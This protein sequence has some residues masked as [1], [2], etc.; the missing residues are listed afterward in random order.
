M[1]QGKS[2]TALGQVRGLGS[3]GHGGTHWLRERAT[4]AALVLLGLWLIASLLLLPDLR[5]GTVLEWLSAPSGA[6]PMFLFVA[7]AFVHSLDG[8][9][10]MIDDYVHDESNRLLAHGIVLFA[11]VGAGALAL[12]SLARIA[13]GA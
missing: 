1:S 8:V 12:F 2:G 6:I 5:R 11:A 3:A 13:F 10:V 7:I 9:K 4:S